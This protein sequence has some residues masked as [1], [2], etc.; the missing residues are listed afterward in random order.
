[1]SRSVEARVEL[2]L[3]IRRRHRH[4]RIHVDLHRFRQ[5]A[6]ADVEL[7]DVLARHDLRSATAA[8]AAAARRLLARRRFSTGTAW[9]TR[10]ARATGPAAASAEHR[11]LLRGI[12]AKIP[13]VPVHAGCLRHRCDLSDR[14]ARLVRHGDRRL[15]LI[16][17]QVVI[18]DGAVRRV[19]RAP[20]AVA[21]IAVL[22]PHSP[23][24]RRPVCRT[25]PRRS[26]SPRR[27]AA[28]ARCRP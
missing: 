3:Q 18:D 14:L 22:V 11:S 27:C 25:A 4:A 20:H 15:R 16:R 1:M 24:R 23:S 10:P 2:R 17:L 26:S 21:E 19:R 6:C 12:V 9:A 8:E 7:D 28:A 13:H 5:L